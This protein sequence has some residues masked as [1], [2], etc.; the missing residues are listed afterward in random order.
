MDPAAKVIIWIYGTIATISLILVI[1]FII[2][3]IE[4]KKKEDFEARDN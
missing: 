1:Y 3:R 2:R 4:I